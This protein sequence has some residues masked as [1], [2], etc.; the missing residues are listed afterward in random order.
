[1]REAQAELGRL[2][3][4]LGGVLLFKQR[5]AKAEL[6][7]RAAISSSLKSAISQLR[8]PAHSELADTWQAEG[9]LQLVGQYLG[10]L[11]TKVGLTLMLAGVLR[12]WGCCTGGCAA[13]VLTGAV[14]GR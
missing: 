11:Q 2:S 9:A 3:A 12:W 1:M 10:A 13:L 4:Q 8:L 5:D 14:A 7:V 6:R